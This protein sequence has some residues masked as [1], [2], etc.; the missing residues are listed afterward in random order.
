MNRQGPGKIEW[1]D[2]TWGVWSGCNGPHDRG[3]C[4]F[5][6]AAAMARR[7]HRDGIERHFTSHLTEAELRSLARMLEKVRGH[8]RPM[9]P[10]RV[11]G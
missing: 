10:G 4:G 11:T 6:Y 8:V 9:R 3:P 7:F 1:C 2:Y 5:C